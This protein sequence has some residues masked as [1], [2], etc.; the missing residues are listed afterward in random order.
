MPK[1]ET[2][3][4]G[5]GKESDQSMNVAD[6]IKK[7]LREIGADGL[8]NPEQECGCS[9]DDMEPCEIINISDCVPAKRVRCEK[10]DGYGTREVEGDGTCLTC[11]ECD[12]GFLFVPMEPPKKPS[13]ICRD[14]DRESRCKQGSPA[15]R[16]EQTPERS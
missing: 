1:G 16:D 15:R 12:D 4:M 8:C 3:V 5:A 13:E 7:Y 9:I 6:I 10:C 11:H 2:T 14:G